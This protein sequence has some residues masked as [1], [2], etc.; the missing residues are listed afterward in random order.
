MCIV[1]S[2]NGRLIF[3]AMSNCPRVLGTDVAVIVVVWAWVGDHCSAAVGG[4]ESALR[5][6]T[7]S[8]GGVSRNDLLAAKLAGL[9]YTGT[10]V[11]SNVM[12]EGPICD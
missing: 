11:D 2:S 12:P 10:V 4:A 5:A 1:N 9:A 7:P 6:L 8:D 3:G